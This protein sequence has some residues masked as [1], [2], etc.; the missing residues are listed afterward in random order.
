MIIGVVISVVLYVILVAS[1]LPVGL[2]LAWLCQD[3]LIKDKKYFF[4]MIYVS[5]AAMIIVYIFYFNASVIF[6]L[7]YFIFILLILIRKG[8]KLEARLSK[9]KLKK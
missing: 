3:E 2:L 9:R 1:I 7:A 4:A 8:R 6:A 5:L